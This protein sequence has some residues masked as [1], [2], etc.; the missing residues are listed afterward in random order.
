M[1]RITRLRHVTIYT[2]GMASASVW[3]LLLTETIS[4]LIGIFVGT[5]LALAVDRSN[6]HRR[7]RRR[8]RVI[9]RSL[10]Q[11]LTED[12]N[13][14]QSVRVAYLTTPF[15]K[16]FYINT[17]AWETALSGGELADLMGDDLADLLANQYARLIRIRYY[18]DLLTR[19]WLAPTEIPGYEDIRRGFTQTILDSLTET[20]NHHG[21]LMDSLNR[22]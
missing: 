3:E 10:S 16:S 9:V 15:G 12:F 5:L 8:A 20:I 6:E 17:V 11:E 2:V 13:T 19:L 21:P 7:Q 14:L 4:A 18:V 22:A 1:T